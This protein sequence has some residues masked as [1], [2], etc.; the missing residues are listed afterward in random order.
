MCTWL[1]S[2]ATIQRWPRA[3]KGSRD[4]FVRGSELCGAGWRKG[5][6]RGSNKRTR[7]ASPPLGESLQWNAQNHSFSSR[8]SPQ[9]ARRRLRHATQPDASAAAA[10]WC[11]AFAHSPSVPA[12]PAASSP[13]L[14]A[15]PSILDI[16]HSLSSSRVNAT[17][18][19]VRHMCL[20]CDNQ[21]RDTGQRGRC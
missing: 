2:S 18:H 6:P 11:H 8:S 5:E 12:A 1:S 10:I 4:V 17:S 3:A 13:S 19:P 20:V 15:P 14:L 16:R 7:P 9:N 21:L